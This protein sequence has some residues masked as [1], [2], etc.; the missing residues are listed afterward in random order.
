MIR[1]WTT[2]TIK[3]CCEILDSQRVPLNSEER[4]KIQG[5]I[6]YYGANGVQGYINKFLFDEELILIAEDGGNFDQFA[7]KP[8]AYKISGKSW[9]NNHAHILRAKAGFNQDFIFYSIVNKNILFFIQGGTR[10]KLNQSDLKSIEIKIPENKEEQSTI[11][12][13]LTTIDQAIKKTEQLIAKYERIKTGLMQDLLTCGVDEQGNIRSE[14]THE[15]KDSP[16]GRIPKEWEVERLGNLCDIKGRIG[17]QGYTVEDLDTEGALVLG[18]THISKKHELDLSKPVFLKWKKY[19]D[20]PEIHVQKGNI[21]LVKTGNTIG[22]TVLITKDIGS[23]TI[24]PNTVILRN[25]NIDNRY[26]YLFMTTKYFQTAIWDFVLIGAQPSVNQANIKSILVPRP[27]S[28]EIEQITI[29]WEN[30]YSSIENER[31]E[32]QKLL[33][34]KTAL[35]QD[36]LTGKVHVDALMNQ[37]QRTI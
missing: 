9:V 10:S 17:W 32:L 28:G 19:W 23:A 5:N 27:L 15:F 18:A 26:L 22:K 11:T 35:M 37:I 4:A 8:I 13:V 31:S 1:N 34:L 7:T 25:F 33:S 30:L 16:L 3:D 6:P 12:T 2:Y 36:L 20:A 29:M 21:I 14:E 24:N